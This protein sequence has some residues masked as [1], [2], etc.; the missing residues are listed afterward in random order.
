MEYKCSVCGKHI[1]DDL[2]VYIHHTEK[3]IADQIHA[4]HP[5][6]T[7]K[8]GLCRKCVEYYRNEIKGKTS[9]EG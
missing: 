2:M 5:D 4:D 6:W 1:K 8:G 9:G 7:E 3:H